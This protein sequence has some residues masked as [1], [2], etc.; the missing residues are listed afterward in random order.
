VDEGNPT[1]HYSYSRGPV[2]SHVGLSEEPEDTLYIAIFSSNSTHEVCVAYD[3]DWC[4]MSRARDGHLVSKG[5][6]GIRTVWHRG[7]N[8][9][10]VGLDKPPKTGPSKASRGILCPTPT[11]PSAAIRRGSQD[12]PPWSGF[13]RLCYGKA[14]HAAPSGEVGRGGEKAWRPTGDPT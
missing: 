4:L 1:S 7:K 11:T 10:G 12:A 5:C 13:F 3:H 8:R 9:P 2:N 14:V 6:R